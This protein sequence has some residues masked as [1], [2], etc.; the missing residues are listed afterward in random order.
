MLSNVLAS[1]K[2]YEENWKE[3]ERGLTPAEFVA[4]IE[5]AEIEASTYGQ[6]IC[7]H[8][9]GG[10]KQYIPV[11]TKATHTYCVGDKVNMSEVTLVV[12]EK[13]GETIV[14]AE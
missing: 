9:V 1:L 3:V 4:T 2:K 8:L 11:S 6:S 10:G 12:L 5:Y 13:N 14:R 7:L